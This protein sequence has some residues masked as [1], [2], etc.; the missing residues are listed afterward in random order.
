VIGMTQ[1]EIAIFFRALRNIEAIDADSSDL[2]IEGYDF[3]MDDVKFAIFCGDVETMYELDEFINHLDA[4]A[5]DNEPGDY[6]KGYQ[7]AVN[8]CLEAAS[9]LLESEAA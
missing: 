2:Y 6:A 9:K 3:V 7:D 8:I 4:F 5:E 1:T